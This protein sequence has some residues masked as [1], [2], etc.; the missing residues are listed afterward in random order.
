MI[1]VEMVVLVSIFGP[2]QMLSLSSVTSLFVNN[3]PYLDAKRERIRRRVELYKQQHQDEYLAYDVPA[4]V[5]RYSRATP[6]K[7]FPM[8]F[9]TNDSVSV[10]SASGAAKIHPKTNIISTAS[11]LVNVED[12]DELRQ[13]RS[14]YSRNVTIHILNERGVQVPMT[15]N[16]DDDLDHIPPYWK[17]VDN[18]YNWKYERDSSGS[19]AG[20]SLSAD[21]Q[22][23]ILG[24]DRCEAYR[25]AVPAHV[26]AVGPAGLF[27]SGTNLLADLFKKN[28]DPPKALRFIVRFASWQVPWGKRKSSKICLNVHVCPALTSSMFSAPCIETQPFALPML[29][30]FLSCSCSSQ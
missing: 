22:P 20:K 26:R 7:P 9:N 18:Y 29:Y 23:I 4:Q 1:S 25:R 2:D 14:K 15:N 13:V 21:E 8:L 12:E 16:P 17:I 11:L 19:S 30:C 3:E 24:M 27:S 5:Q 28:C 10:T 6:Y